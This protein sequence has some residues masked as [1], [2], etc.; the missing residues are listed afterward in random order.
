MASRLPPLNPLRAFEATARRGAVSAAARELNVTHGAV[1]HQI[2]ALEESLG[3]VLF[4][5]GG[6]RLKLT[7]QG[8]LL[9]PAVT[10]AFGEIA[11]ATALMKQP[12]TSGDITITCVPAL[13]SLWL[14]PRLNAFTD[15]FPGVRVTLIASNDPDHLRSLDTDVCLLYGD[16]YWPD[17]WTRLWSKLQLFPIASPTLLNS[18][19]LRSL[20]DLSDHTLFHGDREKL[21]MRPEPRPAVRPVAVAVEHADIRIQRPQVVRIVGGDQRDT[22]AGILVSE[23]VEARDQPEREECRHASDGEV[24]MGFRLFHQGGCRRDLAEGIGNGGQQQ[25]TLRGQ[26]QALA[27]ALEKHGPQGFFQRPDLVTDGTVRHL[28]FPRGGRDR[29][30]AGGRFEGAERVERWQARGHEGRSHM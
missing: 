30:A 21:E 22:H 6:K 1:S 20:R 4:E 28:Q 10:N 12:E 8:A 9:L 7:P 15:Q 11:A 5:R 23:G 27:A 3:T 26:L 18:R 17:C 29:A 16:G 14:I 24:A 19:P 13:L 25:R 2:R